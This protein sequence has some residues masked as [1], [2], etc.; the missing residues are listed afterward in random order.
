MALSCESTG[1]L[2][3]SR[4][5]LIGSLLALLPTCAGAQPANDEPVAAWSFNGRLR[6]LARDIAGGRHH[7]GARASTEYVASPGAHALLFDGVTSHLVIRNHPDL[8]MQD[9]V[10]LDA[11]VWLDDL[12]FTEPQCLVDKGGERYRLQIS[13]GGE[14]M[15]GLKN[16]QGRFDLSGGRLEP[17]RWHRITGVF[18]RPQARLYIDGELVREGTWDQPIGPGGDL[19]L[20]SKGG[21]TYFFR[22][23]LDEVRIYRQA[24]PPRNEDTPTRAAP[25][26][27]GMEA[28]MDLTNLP[29]GGVRI[30]TG[31]ATFEL[32]EDGMLSAATVAAE[33]VVS[34]N[35]QPLLSADV[36]ES[37]A[38]DGWSDYAPGRVIEATCRVTGH[39][40]VR[41]GDRFRATLDVVLGFGDGD[42]IEGNLTLEF[43]AGSPSLTV[44]SRFEPRGEFRDRFLRTL[45]LRLPLALNKR[46]RV[47]Q[48]G[49]RGVR[50]NTRHWYQFHVST[51]SRLLEEPDHNIWREF[52]IDQHTDHDYHIWR[53][54]SQVTAPLSMQRGIAAPGWMAAY[55]ERAGL[56]FAYRGMSERAPKSLRVGADGAGEAFI[57]LWSASQPALDIHSP[58]AGAVFGAPHTTDWLLF[59]EDFRFSQPDLMLARHWG[60]EELSS[61]PPPRSEIPAGELELWT[62][63]SGDAQ[64]PLVSG[65]LP[66]P[67]AALADPS[68]VRLRHDAADVP[69]QTRPLAYWPDGSIKWLLLTFPPDDGKVSDAA[70]GQAAVPFDLTRRDGS[71]RR[72][73]LEYG[74][75]S[76]PGTPTGAL[77][78]RRDGDTV[79]LDTGPLQ[80]ELGLGADW[81]RSVKLAGREMLAAGARSYVDF[82]RTD[83]PYTCGATHAQGA[84]DEGLFVAE[85]IDLEETG[86]LRATV[87]LEGM[88]G[89]QEPSRMVLRVEAYAGRTVLRV[90]QTVEFLHQN[91][92]T[93]FVRRMGLD[94]P[95]ASLES[96]RV[97]VGGQDGPVPV[98]R[99]RRA[100]IRQ[101]SHLG[102]TAWRQAAGE[103]FQRLVEG[104]HRCRGWL[105]L[106]DDAGGVAV[107]LRDMWQQFPNE[108][109]AD[110]EAGKLTAALW[111]ESGPVMDVRRYSNYPHASQGESAR[112]RSSWVAETWY[113]NDCFVGTSK[114]HEMLLYFHGPDVLPE[115][116][117]GVVADFQR[118]PLVYAGGRW[119][120]DTG[121]L[122]PHTVVDPD[123]FPRS[124]ANLEHFARFWMHHQELW[125][126]YGL[127][128]YGDVQH[129][130]R[131]GYGSI[132]GPDDLREVLAGEQA[133]REVNI[134]RARIADYRPNHDWAFDNGRWGWTN[135]EGLPN[136][137]LQLQYMRTGDRD[138]FFFVE[139]MARHVRD[140]DM[141]HD[142]KWFGRGTR[143]GVQ[144]WSDGNHEERQTTHS[145]FRYH[146]YLSG[147]MRSRDFATRLY[148]QVYKQ[149]D[150]HVHAA[151]SGRLQGLLTQWEMT[152]SEEVADILAKYVPCFGTPEG[153][154]ES[155]H[156]DFPDVRL[157]EAKDSLNSGNMFFWTFG[158]GHGVIEYFELTGNQAIRDA[159]LKTAD[160]ALANGD[161]GLRRKAVAFAAHYAD[162][163]GPYRAAIADWAAK[164]GHRYLVQIVPHNPAHYSGPRSFLRGSVAGALFAIN[165]LPYLMTV[166]EGDPPI[167]DE[168]R[169][170]D[171]RGGTYYGEPMLSWQSEYD[172]PEFEEYLRIKFPQP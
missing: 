4:A 82:L 164:S 60:V 95:V 129:Y 14:P 33:R 157:V 160:D 134:A 122:L 75:A 111:P 94:L 149:R 67:K 47:V 142:G 161:I 39:N 61:D 88:T 68:H 147:D 77:R 171:E 99:G 97:T 121:V 106:A 41:E 125:A 9:T 30:D 56:L 2:R 154:V 162:D 148:E 138:L 118:P 69:L 36:L 13:P 166:L 85:K 137:F 1:H 38:Y 126:W 31:A 165:D 78:A 105:D 163:P 79:H 66:F 48:A 87:R 29:A 144:H 102:Y 5:A 116:I 55:D 89:S 28:K 63:P 172:L 83:E 16:A 34:D 50:W 40:F 3:C 98:E 117:D 70:P 104:K 123:R 43:A 133:S 84:P 57:C 80:I 153:L 25:G 146:H 91:P 152:G 108:L 26:V 120:H 24:R 76:R 45:A 42:A 64:A 114:T 73:D 141:R 139:A 115:A 37:A 140:V 130:F 54:E 150:V 18:D 132:L 156:V 51:T 22:G 145:E 119:Y 112:P 101:H 6:R 92:R 35:T 159:L 17:A 93:A 7:A 151:H 109:V 27:A 74:G 136:L 10:T 11:W 169:Q 167:T 81:L 44:T 155:P 20:G 113:P 71:K 72:Y 12:Q 135:T 52:V 58:Q 8:V 49:D 143:H 23:R 127:W 19:Y 168:M 59:A 124:D 170:A 46:K 53:S 131:G 15:F 65:G 158:A 103:R 107:A 32:T 86:P 128:D 110:L 21:V 90:F 62:A 100:G 96:P